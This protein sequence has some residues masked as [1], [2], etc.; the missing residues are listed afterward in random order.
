MKPTCHPTI[1]PLEARIAPATL[2]NPTT[3]TYQ[4]IDGDNVTVKLNKAVLDESTI[5]DV[6]KFSTGAVDGCNTTPQ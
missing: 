3:V 4:D 2:L 1:E 6:L 5:N